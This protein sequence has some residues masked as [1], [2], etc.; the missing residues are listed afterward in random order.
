MG[1]LPLS[2]LPLW[3]AGFVICFQPV[4]VEILYCNQADEKK[5]SKLFK[6][7]NVVAVSE[8]QKT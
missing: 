8:G 5:E 7:D 4:V 2:M 1:P 3:R 6:D